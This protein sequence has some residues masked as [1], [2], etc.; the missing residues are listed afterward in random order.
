MRRRVDPRQLV[1]FEWVPPTR[2]RIVRRLIACGVSLTIS[3]WS[4]RTGIT[5][6]LLRKRKRKGWSDQ[7]TVTTPDH[8]RHAGLRI[9]IGHPQSVSW[10]RDTWENDDHAWY[11]VMHQPDG[12]TLE[13]IGAVMG[14][15]FERVRQIE[16]EALDKLRQLAEIRQ[17]MLDRGVIV[18]ESDEPVTLEDLLRFQKAI[19]VSALV[20]SDQ[21]ERVA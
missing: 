16:Q 9:P 17:E 8:T 1:L 19:V 14:L 15:G 20:A 7:E 18:A 6:S 4:K 21:G 13:Q 10:T 2:V 11:V 12:L 5:R 3:E